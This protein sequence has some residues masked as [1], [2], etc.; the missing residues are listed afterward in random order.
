[1]PWYDNYIGGGNEQFIKNECDAHS[2]YMSKINNVF[3]HKTTSGGSEMLNT[4][5]NNLTGGAETKVN[6]HREIINLFLKYLPCKDANLDTKKKLATNINNYIDNDNSS[7]KTTLEISLT[8]LYKTCVSQGDDI[9]VDCPKNLENYQKE[10]ERLATQH[11]DLVKQFNKLLKDKEDEVN[12]AKKG[13]VGKLTETVAR[14]NNEVE[15]LKKERINLFDWNTFLSKE[16]ISLQEHMT[17][18]VGIDK[19]LLI[20][21]EDA[22]LKIQNKNT[23]VKNLFEKT[24][25]DFKE[26]NEKRA[27]SSEAV[28]KKLVDLLAKL[29]D[30]ISDG[31]GDDSTIAAIDGIINNIKT[32]TKESESLGK[33]Q[34]AQI[35]EQVQKHINNIKKNIAIGTPTSYN[36][37]KTDSIDVLNKTHIM[38]QDALNAMNRLSTDSEGFKGTKV[39]GQEKIVI[40]LLKTLNETLDDSKNNFTKYTR[41]SNGEK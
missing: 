14:L 6:K 18:S 2:Q 27:K 10:T 37:L 39:E 26:N 24:L 34:K 29:T 16:L 11:D 5:I 21:A 1:M 35:E 31:S 25:K 33:K 22:G 20:L 13:D 12:K 4:V 40:K 8:D 7:E 23:T 41:F 17:T 19:N 36:K 30:C 9:D 38:G 15:A 28:I 32:M 3:M